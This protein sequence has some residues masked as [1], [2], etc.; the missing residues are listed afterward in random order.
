LPFNA[1]DAH[2]VTR[3]LGGCLENSAATLAAP[4]TSCGLGNQGLQQAGQLAIELQERTLE[5]RVE[6]EGGELA[7]AAQL[8][9]RSET[10]FIA[11]RGAGEELADTSVDRLDLRA[12]GR[13]DLE[14]AVG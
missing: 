9:D 1:Q 12:G 6:A 10:S 13:V 7:A 2:A 8:C 4:K 14:V 5:R 3:Q 11:Q